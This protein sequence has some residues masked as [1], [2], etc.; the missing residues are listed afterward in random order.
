MSRVLVIGSGAIAREHVR[1][2]IALGCEVQLAARNRAA[3][4]ALRSELGPVK[5]AASI[6]HFLTSPPR[7]DDVVIVTTPPDSHLAFVQRA[8]ASGRHVLCEK[9]LVAS[10]A[11]LAELDRLIASS[12]HQLGCCSGRFLHY[13]TS[14]RAKELLAEGAIGAPYHATFVHKS[15][16]NRPG[17]EYQPGSYWFLDRK[18]A[19]GGVLLDWAAY[20]LGLLNWVLDVVELE[21][22]HAFV[23]RPETALSLPSG[24]VYDVEAHAGATLRLRTARSDQVTVSYERSAA[25]H[26][27]QRELVEIEGTRG[28]LRWDW[29]P[30]QNGGRMALVHTTDADGT[31]REERREWAAAGVQHWHARPLAAFREH[32][33]GRAVEVPAGRRALFNLACVFAIYQAATEGRPVRVRRAEDAASGFSAP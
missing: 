25:T 27:E 19:G 24:V 2:A 6:E 32:L 12:D 9:P 5:L 8:L 22:L 13:P 16:R 17:I 29:L 18:A 4:E 15:R 7:D 26:G 10:A 14:A 30:W 28:A 11:E 23:A 31:P 3:A 1:A 20:D 21:V 33:A